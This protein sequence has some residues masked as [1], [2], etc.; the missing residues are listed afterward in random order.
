MFPYCLIIFLIPSNPSSFF[1]YNIHREGR[2][3]C[4]FKISYSR[5]GHCMASA[6]YLVGLL[7]SA[8]SSLRG[9]SNG[10]CLFSVAAWSVPACF[11]FL[12]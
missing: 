7:A 8:F 3:V 11:L 6:F 12:I 1:A 10:L 2:S 4:I 9:L 5:P